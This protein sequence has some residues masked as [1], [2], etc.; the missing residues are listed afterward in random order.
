MDDPVRD[1]ADKIY[2]VKERA[3]KDRTFLDSL[4]A[5]PKKLLSEQGVAM[6]NIATVSAEYH[7]GYEVVILPTFKVTPSSSPAPTK[8]SDEQ[9]KQNY[10]FLD[11]H[12]F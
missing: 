5:D 3:K 11:C 9:N 12:N 6:D 1:L 10:D 2:A 7:D 8:P 4:L